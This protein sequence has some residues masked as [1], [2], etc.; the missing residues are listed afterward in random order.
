MVYTSYCEPGTGEQVKYACPN[1]VP[2][3]IYHVIC[4]QGIGVRRIPAP[5]HALGPSIQSEYRHTYRYRYIDIYT[6]DCDCAALPAT[7]VP[8][9]RTITSFD[10][11]AN[12]PIIRVDCRYTYTYIYQ[13]G[14]MVILVWNTIANTN[15][16]IDNSDATNF[17][18]TCHLLIP[19]NE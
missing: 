12:N 14:D 8:S 2:T 11:N 5:R 9:L 4:K 3:I 6:D 13:H 18:L 7:N 17:E 19:N 15:E 10:S 1:P 16:I